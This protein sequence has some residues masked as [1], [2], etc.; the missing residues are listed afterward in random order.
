VRREEESEDEAERDEEPVFE[1]AISIATPKGQPIRILSNLTREPVPVALRMRVAS[2][3]PT[4]G[5]VRVSDFRLEK[6]FR[7]KATVERFNLDFTSEG[8]SRGRVDGLLR[9]DLT[10]YEIHVA[11][12]GPIEQPTYRF[13]SEPPLPEEQ[14]LAVL[15]FGRPLEELDPE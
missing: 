9:V 4:S 5:Q 13:W 14:I 8:P 10:D 3:V 1:Y 11:A 2:D 12:T 7:L 15:L 6:F